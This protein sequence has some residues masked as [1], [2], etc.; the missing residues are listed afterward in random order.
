MAAVDK[1]PVIEKCEDPNKDSKECFNRNL[2]FFILKNIKAVKSIKQEEKAYAVFNISEN[3]DI[4]EIRVRSA[5]KELEKKVKK[6]LTKLE[7]KSPA[8]LEGKAVAVSCALPVTYKVRHLDSYDQ[9]FQEF[10][11]ELPK[12]TET[13]VPPLLASCGSEP[14]NISCLEETVENLIR[15]SVDTKPGL[16]V[17]Y[18]FEINENSKVNQVVVKSPE[19][20]EAGKQI[21]AILEALNFKAPAKNEKKQPIK[22]C[23]YDQLIF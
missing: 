10:I 9:F 5:N 7:V 14:E 19:D 15:R 16:I 11:E 6:V 18:Y 3:G 21:K 2:S 23:F 13:D 20:A 4:S 8:Q 17:D 12:A 1:A 22:S